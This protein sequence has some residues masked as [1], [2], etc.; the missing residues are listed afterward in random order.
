[1][2][3]NSPCSSLATDSTSKSH[4]HPSPWGLCEERPRESRY[5]LRP[6]IVI[7]TTCR[8]RR[9]FHPWTCSPSSTHS[10]TQHQPHCCILTQQILIRIEWFSL[11]VIN[12]PLKT[13]D[14]WSTNFRKTHLFHSSL[15]FGKGRTQLNIFMTE[16][17]S[18]F[19][20]QR[21]IISSKLKFWKKEWHNWIYLWS[22]NLKRKHKQ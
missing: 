9:P 15:N 4:E 20:Y 22:R 16:K 2:R 8:N 6:R 17:L 19:R 18:I 11:H 7:P 13:Q 21:H 12:Q 14:I 3:I 5:V 10:S 1:M